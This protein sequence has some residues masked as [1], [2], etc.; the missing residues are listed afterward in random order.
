[1]SGGR[2]SRVILAVAAGAALPILAVTIDSSYTVVMP[3]YERSGVAADLYKAA[4]VMCAALK[5]GAGIEPSRSRLRKFKGGR[6]I[7]IGEEAAKRAGIV[8]EMMGDFSNV[9]AEKDGDIYLFGRDQAIH[10]GIAAN[11]WRV[12][13]IPT[14]RAI[15]RFMETYMDV[16]F[17]MPGDVGTDIPSIENVEVPDGT[18][19]R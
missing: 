13:P 9:I 15:A 12:S 8:P 7:Y 14:L 1:M 6:A 5:E 2:M 19:S 4:G 3:E 16:R 10:P 11:N 17:L 18:F